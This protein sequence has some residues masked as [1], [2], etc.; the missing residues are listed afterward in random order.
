MGTRPARLFNMS[1]GRSLLDYELNPD[2]ETE[3]LWIV[4]FG[5]QLLLGRN[6]EII[7]MSHDGVI[8]ERYQLPEKWVNRDYILL[9]FE[10]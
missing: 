4:P 2:W 5:D 10:N 7:M 3:K 9:R 8:L 6:E 1:T